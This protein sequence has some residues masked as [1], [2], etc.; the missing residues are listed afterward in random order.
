[1][2]LRQTIS[3]MHQSGVRKF[4]E[5]GP[6]GVL[7]A[8][9]S[10]ILPD[11]PHLA[12]ASNLANRSGLTKIH[13]LLAALYVQDVPAN[14]NYLYERR[15]PIELDIDDLSPVPTT[16]SRLLLKH[17]ELKLLEPLSLVSPIEVE[18]SL[19]SE[20]L[21]MERF[22]AT[23]SSF[24]SKLNQAA[25]NVMRGFYEHNY[26]PPQPELMLPDPAQADHQD[27]PFL[28]RAQ[29]YQRYRCRCLPDP[30]SG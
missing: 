27:L 14:Y 4:V 7:T 13:H 23:N 30:E 12:V 8:L 21:V 25:G 24:Y 6:N 10:G 9:I 11:K 16:S 26:E 28:A 29:A 5:V 3:E 20:D 19:E 15:A 22:L 2:A 18:Q 1:M 17:G